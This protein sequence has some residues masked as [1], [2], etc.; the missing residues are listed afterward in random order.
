MIDLGLKDLQMSSNFLSGVCVCVYARANLIIYSIQI[1]ISEGEYLTGPL[2][3][4]VTAL[5]GLEFEQL[6]PAS[7][8]RV[9]LHVVS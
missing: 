1:W 7:R 2:L 5:L 3:I 4:A 6:A 9:V 8:Q